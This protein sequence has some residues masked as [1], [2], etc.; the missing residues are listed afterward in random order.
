MPQISVIVPVYKVEKDL[1]RCVDSLINQT[2]QDIEIILVDD[3]SPDEC[4]AICDNY[5]RQDKRIKVIHKKNGGVS[6]ARNDGL[7]I[8]IGDWVIFCD[9]DDWMELDA[10][11]LLVSCGN[12]NSVDVVMADINRVNDGNISYVQF[13]DSDFITHE[14]KYIQS[15]VEAILYPSYCKN[16]SKNNPATGF[17]G[18]PWN[19]AI[20]RKLLME[21][22]I[23]FD[24]ELLGVCDDMLFSA[25]VLS[26][27]ESL[28]Y[29]S[30]PI[31]NYMMFSAS[32]TQTHKANMV[33]INQ[34]IFNA[35][36]N[37]LKCCNEDEQFETAYAA[38]VIRRFEEMLR[39][40]F[41]NKKNDLELPERLKELKLVM[42]SEPYYS[43]SN[44]VDVNILQAQHKRVAKLL[45]MQSANGL[46][47]LYKFK[48]VRGGGTQLTQKVDVKLNIVCASLGLPI[49]PCMKVCA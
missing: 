46:C 9:S 39:F 4:P 34:R 14:S 31:Y 25:Y 40:Y 13:F 21:N 3:G 8:A 12:Q 2:L 7:A 17:Y 1:T 41:F 26:S 23:L 27:C 49:E 11:Q 28:A 48:Q 20:R 30:E 24:V 32:I 36:E 45:K 38:F 29:I 18:G 37:Y 15:I 44:L 6:A 5:A 33:N 19:K 35:F 47:T 43:A 42:K 22:S 10:C 16:P